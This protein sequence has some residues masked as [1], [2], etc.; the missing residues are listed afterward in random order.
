MSVTRKCVFNEHC[1]FVA[2]F[3]VWYKN[4]IL[5]KIN[6]DDFMGNII[7]K[8]D[9]ESK[10]KKSKEFVETLLHDEY[11]PLNEKQFNKGKIK[12]YTEVLEYLKLKSNYGEK[13]KQ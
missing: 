4:N 9:L 2:F 3:E 6:G 5:G 11:L 7:S 13:E 8:L 12:A 1:G 10:I